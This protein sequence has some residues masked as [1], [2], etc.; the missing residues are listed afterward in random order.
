MQ[1]S[2]STLPS[3][4]RSRLESSRWSSFCALL[5]RTH[6]LPSPPLF[7]V[8]QRLLQHLLQRLLQGLP[9]PLFPRP[10]LGG[11][12]ASASRFGK[13]ISSPPKHSRVTTPPPPPPP[14]PTPPPPPPSSS[15][16]LPWGGHFVISLHRQSTW[17]PRRFLP[18]AAASKKKNFSLCRRER[19][20]D[21]RRWFLMLQ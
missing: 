11:S 8:F 19:R 10:A 17:P 12:S 2:L 4:G 13:Q 21:P 1:N 14:P 6:F 15:L 16:D 5:L 7:I 18:A 3:P 9:R 20:L